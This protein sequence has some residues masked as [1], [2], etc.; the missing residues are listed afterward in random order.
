MIGWRG[1]ALAGLGLADATLLWWGGGGTPALQLMAVLAG[2][3]AGS[4]ALLWLALQRRFE[5]LPLWWVLGLALL[6]RIVAAQ[7]M[8]L[9][10]D[11]HYRYLWDGFRTA[12]TLDP[13][14]L[15][16]LAYFGNPDLA[17]RWQDILGGINHPDIPTLYGPVLQGLFAAAYAIAPGK[18][19]ALQALLVVVD[20]AC[21]ALLVQQRVGTR[22]VLAYALHPLILKEAIASAHPDGLVALWLLLALVYWQRRGAARIGMRIDIRIG[23]RIGVLM[24]LAV[25][26][27]VAALVVLPLFLIGRGWRAA[28]CTAAAF[29][30]T[31]LALYLPFIAGGGSEGAGLLVFGTQWRFNPLLYR[32]VEV[33]LSPTSARAAAA[34]LIVLGVAYLAWR[35]RSAGTPPRAEQALLLL[36]LFSPVVNPWYWLWALGPALLARRLPLVAV[37]AAGALSYINTTVLKEAGW[38]A[39]GGSFSVAWPITALQ[40]LVLAVALYFSA[41]STRAATAPKPLV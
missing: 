7:A 38:L 9:L 5:H 22:W 26:T 27:K 2:A 14:R 15:P 13:Y 39:S 12:T 10:E 28:A 17:P 35:Q 11:D 23:V 36:L 24:A 33:L 32:V 1:P 16:P 37:A 34:V 29:S 40:L 31:L 6:L 8:P 25:G 30:I 3:A 19:G 4:V 20:L 21:L 41:A 18:V